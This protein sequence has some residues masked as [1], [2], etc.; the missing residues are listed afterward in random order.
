MCMSE[1][2]KRWGLVRKVFTA[3]S[4]QTHPNK[5]SGDGETAGGFPCLS[6]NGHLHNRS[7]VPT[8]CLPATV[9][10]MHRL[11]GAKKVNCPANLHEMKMLCVPSGQPV[12]IQWHRGAT[13]EGSL[14]D[15]CRRQG[16]PREAGGAAWS[17]AMVW[18]RQ[19]VQLLHSLRLAS[20]VAALAMQPESRSL[21]HQPDACSLTSSAIRGQPQL[22]QPGDFLSLR[23][24]KHQPPA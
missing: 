22:W 4:V 13:G 5:L 21:V 14:P 9:R 17:P 20:V 7:A 24:P 11:R 16:A 19:R 18:K 15:T 23:Q 2:K 8:W 1:G 10:K 6:S 12:Q 3:N